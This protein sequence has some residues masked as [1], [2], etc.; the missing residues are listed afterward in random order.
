MTAR[1]LAPGRKG[2]KTERSEAGPL[3]PAVGELGDT[4]PL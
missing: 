2:R 1:T 4:L 3:S